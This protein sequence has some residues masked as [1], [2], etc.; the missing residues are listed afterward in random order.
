M[1]QG[2]GQRVL[3]VL[4]L[5]DVHREQSG[6]S[7]DGRVVE[8]AVVRLVVRPAVDHHLELD[9]AERPVVEDDDLDREPVHGH[10]QDLA[11]QHAVT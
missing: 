6:R 8:A 10:G 2:D 9:H 5:L 11:E 3:D 4:G 7:G 1:R